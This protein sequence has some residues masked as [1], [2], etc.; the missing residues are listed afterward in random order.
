MERNSIFYQ[1]S[2]LLLRVIPFVAREKCF[3]LKG[4]T[5]L[6]FFVRD[7][8][9]LSV[10]I[11]LTYIP[12][13][14][15]ELSLKHINAALGQITATIKKAQKSFKVTEVKSRGDEGLKKIFVSNGHAQI[16]IEVNEVFRG[17]ILGFEERAVTQ[18]V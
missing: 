3:A 8:P 6:N 5:A 1:Q 18:K 12:L 16:K 2:E 11:D 7:L 10:D 9:R 14:P 13:E 17:Y 15:R 4:G